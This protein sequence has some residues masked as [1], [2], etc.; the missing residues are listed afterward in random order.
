MGLT[1]ESILD[2]LAVPI[3]VNLSCRLSLNVDESEER[4]LVATLIRKAD[5]L[6]CW[7]KRFSVAI[8]ILRA[9]VQRLVYITHVM[10]QQNHCYRFCDRALV[11]FRLLAFQHANKIGRA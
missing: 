1:A 7:L 3:A 10:R 8:E 5:I 6:L 2:C 4:E 11:C 9:D